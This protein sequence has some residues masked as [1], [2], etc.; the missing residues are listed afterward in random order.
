M[1]F[2]KAGKSEMVRPCR[3]TITTFLVLL[4]RGHVWGW[5]LVLRRT[6]VIVVSVRALVYER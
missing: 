3:N 2:P 6:E 1:E 4:L 5:R